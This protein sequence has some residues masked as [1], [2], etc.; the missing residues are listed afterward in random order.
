MNQGNSDYLECGTIVGGPCHGD[1][2]WGMGIYEADDQDGCD[3]R[4]FTANVALVR[5]LWVTGKCA[6]RCT[7]GWSLRRWK[8][9][10][11][12]WGSAVRKDV[13]QPKEAEKTP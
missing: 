6:S 4:G 7:L 9:P 3:H 5:K 2:I 1:Q 12:I 8:E 11:N 10:V 13:Q